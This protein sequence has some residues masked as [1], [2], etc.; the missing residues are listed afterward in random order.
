MHRLGILLLALLLQGMPA[1]SP[2]D[3]LVVQRGDFEKRLVFSGELQGV[4]SFTITVPR[5]SE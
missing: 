4:D 5:V 3:N 1:E 2:S